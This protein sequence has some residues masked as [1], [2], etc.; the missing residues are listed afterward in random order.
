M[1]NEVKYETTE[2]THR[3]GPQGRPTGQAEEH[4]MYS[5]RISFKRY[6]AQLLTYLRATNIKNRIIN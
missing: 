1:K 3:A 2:T 4:S 5:K 6:E